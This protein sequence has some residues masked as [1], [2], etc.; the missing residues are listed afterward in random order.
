[1]MGGPLFEAHLTAGVPRGQDL[2]TLQRDLERLATAILVEH[3]PRRQADPAP[4][5]PALMLSTAVA[6]QVH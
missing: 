5:E 4:A 6:R 3:Q 1:M 2:A